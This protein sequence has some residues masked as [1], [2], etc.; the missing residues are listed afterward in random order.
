MAHNESVIARLIDLEGRT[1]CELSV[2]DGGQVPH[3]IEV[4]ALPKLDYVAARENPE[5]PLVL[6]VKK[7]V[8]RLERQ[9]GDGVL[10]YRRET[11]PWG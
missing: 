7:I 3:I 4:P 11:G 6:D 5:Q 2:P 9:A 10:I 1:I 8:Y